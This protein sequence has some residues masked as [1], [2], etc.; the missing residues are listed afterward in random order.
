MRELLRTGA[1]SLGTAILFAACGGGGSSS[2]STPVT[3]P[4]TGGGGGGTGATGN[5][6]VLSDLEYNQGA[7]ENGSK[8][9]LLDIYQPSDIC[10]ANRPTVFFVHGGA[11]IGGSKT[12]SNVPERSAASNDKGFNFVSISYRLVGDAPVLGTTFQIAFDQFIANNTDPNI[13]VDQVEAAFA[14]FEDALAALNWLEANQ[15]EYCLDMSRLAYWGSSAGA[16]T[17]LNVAYASNDFDLSRPDPD[18]VINYWGALALLDTMEFME[19]PF[20]TLH[21]DQDD[22]VDY[23]AA[24]ALADQGDLVGVP[25]TFYTDVGGGHGVNTDKTVNGVPLL[26]LTMDFIEAHIVGGTPLYETANV[27]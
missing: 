15:D 18:V 23:I 19:A 10:D 21:G 7:T 2:G 4:P 17:V 12:G 24:T 27:D 5:P 13:N 6:V 22:T 9:L 3:P 11:F 25:Y 1:L 16:F 8:A 26:D 14:A 20:F